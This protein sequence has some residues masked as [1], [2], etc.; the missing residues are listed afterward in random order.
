MRLFG[1]AMWM[2]LVPVYSGH[3]TLITCNRQ[4]RLPLRGVAMWLV[5]KLLWALLFMLIYTEDWF[6]LWADTACCRNASDTCRSQ[7]FTHNCA[8]HRC[9]SI[10]YFA[11]HHCHSAANFTQSWPVQ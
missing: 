3:C 1:A 7:S 5:P 2:W 4:V 11:V 8:A 10:T 9:P 6:E